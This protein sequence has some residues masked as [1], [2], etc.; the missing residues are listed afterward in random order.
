MQSARR[1]IAAPHC[2]TG[3]AAPTRR[4]KHHRRSALRTVLGR[5]RIVAP[6]DPL[7]TIDASGSLGQSL[8]SLVRNRS[9]A[10]LAR[11]RF[12]PV[13][14]FIV[15]QSNEQAPPAA[16]PA[17][18][19]V[20]RP[21]KNLEDNLGLPGLLTAN[22]PQQTK[23]LERPVRINKAMITAMI[24]ADNNDQ[25]H[26]SVLPGQRSMLTRIALP[27]QGQWA[28]RIDK[29]STGERARTM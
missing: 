22:P 19:P 4:P 28:P 12:G 18:K 1:D 14:V 10:L 13:F 16:R 21:S 29:P 26:Q 20:G 17:D 27:G 3:D 9:A 6:I 5:G 11:S 8:Q 7:L 15:R 24:T 2:V 23:P 25:A